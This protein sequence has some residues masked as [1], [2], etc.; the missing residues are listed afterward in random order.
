MSPLV[1]PTLSVWVTQFMLQGHLRDIRRDI[2]TNTYWTWTRFI[3]PINWDQVIF[4]KKRFNYVTTNSIQK[5][6]T[7]KELKDY[8]L[9]LSIIHS[10]RDN[11]NSHMKHPKTVNHSNSNADFQWISTSRSC[12]RFYNEYVICMFF[13]QQ[14]RWRS[15]ANYGGNIQQPETVF[16]QVVVIYACF[17]RFWPLSFQIT[18]VSSSVKKT[19]SPR[20]CIWPYSSV[21]ELTLDWQLHVC[22]YIWLPPPYFLTLDDWCLTRAA[23]LLQMCAADCIS[24]M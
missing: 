1:F 6:T 24:N 9:N 22:F 14:W 17:C 12:G 23:E 2:L 3:I 20:M 19:S 16:I 7:L 8:T 18:D 21:F 11:P 13:S 5:T 4:L 15:V 10:F